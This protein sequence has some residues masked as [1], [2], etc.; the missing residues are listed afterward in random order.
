MIV[1]VYEAARVCMC[2]RVDEHVHTS[3]KVQFQQ[4]FLFYY[5][6]LASTSTVT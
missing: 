3:Y 5:L 2:S 1:C 6:K 4:V